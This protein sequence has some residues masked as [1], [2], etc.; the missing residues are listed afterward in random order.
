M[1]LL[2]LSF[3]A[4]ASNE[5]LTRA[6]QYRGWCKDGVR[7]ERLSLSRP[8]HTAQGSPVTVLTD[9]PIGQIRFQTGNISGT[10]YVRCFDNLVIA[11]RDLR[12]GELF[13]ASNV[14][15]VINE[16]SPYFRTGF[17]RSQSE[18][19]GF[20]VKGFVPKG[21]VIGRLQTQT[22]QLVRAGS[23]VTV[24]FK[25]PHLRIQSQGTAIQSGALG[26]LVRV[27]NLGSK[28]VI[29]AKVTD[30]ATVTTQ[31]SYEN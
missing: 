22:R 11:T 19:S 7:I 26:D 4:Q 9:P 3:F 29:V 21:Q 25:S 14:G 18:L 27:S 15:A 2:L 8:W 13:D 28:K 12:H 10:A 30:S 5:H 6:I 24:W 17:F 1:I 16:I 20:E 31:N 23:K